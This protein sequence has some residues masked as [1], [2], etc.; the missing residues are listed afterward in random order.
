[1]KRTILN[2]ALFSLLVSVP[3]I[4][5]TPERPF[6][7][8]REQS[9]LQHEWLK[10]RIDSILPL[11]MRSYGIDMWVVAM[12]EYNEDPVFQG[13]V[14]PETF[15][16]RR[17][18]I[19]VFHDGGAVQGFERLAL[20]GSSQGGL[21]EAVRGTKATP[22]GR[23]QELWGSEQWDMFA[24]MVRDRDP[25]TIGVNISAQH[26]FADGLSAGEWE[27]MEAALG[28]DLA[29]RIV[30][31]E[32]LPIDY[33]YVR[34]P[35]ML[36]TFREMQELAWEIIGTAFSNEV[37]TPGVTTTADVVWWMRQKLNDLGLDTWFQPSVD[38]QRMGDLTGNG[39]TVIQRG[40]VLHCDFGVTA[41][42]LN[43]DTQHMGYVLRADETVVPQGLK[44]ALAGAN[45][46]QDITMEA[47]QVGRTGN[48]AL[49]GALA[50]MREAGINGTVYSHPVGD[51]GH[52]AGPLIGLWDRQEGV[53]GRGDVKILP[54]TWYAIEL[55][56]TTA[57]P[58]WD[59]QPVRM[60]LEEDAEMTPGGEMKW[61]LAR[62]TEFHLVR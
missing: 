18:T 53:P 43:T 58:E 33:L 62:Q 44:D 47:M 26:N 48:E 8:L 37:I 23:Q 50:A 24:E 38:V 9:A 12:R 16:A 15:A 13:L 45:R 55:Q 36:P 20:G 40:D 57:V 54:S 1:M 6:G 7:T 28:P 5:Q 32:G 4:A 25:Q 22:D 14:A 35:E 52:G 3:Q 29:G 60:A 19:Y 61:I 30:R 21:Y 31:A 42:G 27:Q 34:A 10:T 49:H 59:N 2:T 56:T 11:L 17:R 51:H 46:L 41:L 39:P